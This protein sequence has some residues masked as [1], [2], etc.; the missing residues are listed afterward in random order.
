MYTC[1]HIRMH[2]VNTQVKL[3]QE[4]KIKQKEQLGKTEV[5][6][7]GWKYRIW[8]LRKQRLQFVSP[9]TMK[10][11]KNHVHRHVATFPS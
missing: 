7:C 3:F 1:I 9:Y 10:D 6:S 8:K 4:G 2:A 5:Y 11:M